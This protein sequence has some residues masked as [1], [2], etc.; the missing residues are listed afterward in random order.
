MGGLACVPRLVPANVVRLSPKLFMDLRESCQEILHLFFKEVHTPPEAPEKSY[1]YTWE[2]DIFVDKK[3][4][5]VGH[6]DLANAFKAVEFHQVRRTSSFAIPIHSTKADMFFQLNIHKVKPGFFEWQTTV[7]AYGDLWLILRKSVKRLGFTINDTGLHL[8]IPE[9]EAMHPKDCLLRLTTDPKEM[10]QFLSLDADRFALGFTSLDDLFAWGTSSRFFRR[11]YFE[12]DVK[13]QTNSNKKA[14]NDMY[15][16]FRRDWLPRRPDVGLSVEEDDSSETHRAR[17]AEEA[18]LRF[19]KR[20]ELRR[21]VQ[22]HRKRVKKDAMWRKIAKTV[23]AEGRLL[24]MTMKALKDQMKWWDG[25]DPVP[26]LRES[27]VDA[28]IIPWV[29]ENWEEAGIRYWVFN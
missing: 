16:A 3:V 21:K 28:E 10:M 25:V 24:G 2:I 13:T 17:L 14:K 1:N 20:D 4:H 23:P 15:L 27:M 19:D 26:A 7:S 6:K 18:L 11:H 12:I 9:I 5:K 29:L 8:R 22:S